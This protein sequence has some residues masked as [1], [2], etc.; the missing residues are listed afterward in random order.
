MNEIRN[1]KITNVF[2]G[3]E[4]HNCVTL[5]IDCE[6]CDW[7]CSYGGYSLGIEIDGIEAVKKLL[8]TFK[9]YDLYELKGKLIRCDIR[10]NRI[11]A[12][13]DIIENR[14]FSFKEFFERG[15]NDG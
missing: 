5:I 13:G 7:G 2:F 11:Y 15:K 1:A 3:I 6:G 14:W 9:I 8:E 10:D 4:D 12:I